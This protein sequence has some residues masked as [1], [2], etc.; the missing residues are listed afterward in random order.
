[1]PGKGPFKVL[2]V[3]AGE[4]VVSDVLRERR[5]IEKHGPAFGACFAGQEVEFVQQRREG[6]VPVDFAGDVDLDG[7]VAFLDYI[8]LKRQIGSTAGAMWGDGDFDFDGDVDRLDFLALRGAFGE[9]VGSP[10]AAP[11]PEPTAVL[12]LGVGA[13]VLLGRRRAE[14]RRRG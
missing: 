4:H 10:A 6:C 11:V 1:M 5:D 8:A 14:R 12:L 13:S 2:V 7:S 3:G 9:T